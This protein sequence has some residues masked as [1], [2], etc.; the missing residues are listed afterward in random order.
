MKNYFP[1]PIVAQGS[2]LLQHIE[3][4]KSQDWTQSQAKL[5]KSFN[6]L[7]SLPFGTDFVQICKEARRTGLTPSAYK[8]QFKDWERGNSPVQLALLPSEAIA[9]E[10]ELPVLGIK[11]VPPELA[12]APSRFY[13]TVSQGSQ[14]W[15]YPIQLEQRKIQ[16]ILP[17]VQRLNWALGLDGAPVD[18]EAIHGTLKQAIDGGLV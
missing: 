3:S 6:R 18:V 10:A 1:E 8:Q 9:P 16:R 13:I 5:I 7:R 17:R 15:H 14:S 12:I 11:P 4:R 2:G